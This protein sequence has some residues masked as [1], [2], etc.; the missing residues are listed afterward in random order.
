MAVS[1][2]SERTVEGSESWFD[3]RLVDDA[4]DE[5]SELTGD[6][7][8]DGGGEDDDE[9][10]AATGLDTAGSSTTRGVTRGAACS[11]R[12]GS[13]AAAPEK[14]VNKSSPVS[15]NAI[16]DIPSETKNI[17]KKEITELITSIPTIR[18]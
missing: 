7:D 13:A 18:P 17:T 5:A 3:C 12:G 14:A 1:H 4:W 10:E 16:A 2:E 15:A 8:E 11:C 6:G 9:G